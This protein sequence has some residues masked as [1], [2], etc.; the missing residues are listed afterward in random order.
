MSTISIT[1]ETPRRGG[2]RVTSATFLAKEL[3]L[4]LAWGSAPGRAS[5]TYVPAAGA[6]AVPS[7]AVVKI[8]TQGQKFTGLCMRDQLAA[9]ANEGTVRRIDWVDFRE[10]LKWDFIYAAFNIQEDRLGSNGFERVWWHVL[11][12][13]FHTGRRTYTPRPLSAD[14]ILDAC[15]GFT[16]RRHRGIYTVETEFYPTY[17]RDMDAPVIGLD[18]RQGRRLG[19]C[20]QEVSDK[21]GLVFSLDHY[22]GPYHLTWVRKGEGT[23]PTYGETGVYPANSDGREVDDNFSGHPT[24]VRVLGDRNVYQILNVPVVRDWLPAWQSFP[25]TF[26]FVRDVYLRGR[27]ANGVRFVVAAEN[28]PDNLIGWHKAGALARTISVADYASLRRRVRLAGEPDAEPYEW[29]DLRSYQGRSR[30][31]MPAWLYITSIVWRAFRPMPFKFR[32]A[33][34]FDVS[35]EDMEVESG[36]LAAVDHDPV[37]GRMRW[38]RDLPVAGQGYAVV[39]GYNVGADTFRMADPD[40][41]QL[42]QWVNYQALWTN[43]GFQVDRQPGGLPTLLFDE[44]LIKSSNFFTEVDGKAVLKA[45]PTLTVPAVRA[46][47]V[48]RAEVFSYT[49]GSGGRDDREYV[50]GLYGQFIASANQS[51]LEEIRFRDGKGVV[52]KAKEIASARLAS[53]WQYAGGGYTVKGS[54]QTRLSAMYDRVTLRTGPGGTTETVDFTKERSRD[55]FVP[56]RDLDRDLRQQSLLPGEDKLRQE[57][58]DLRLIASGLRS[59]KEV[60]RSL[61]DIFHGATDVIR[62]SG[63]EDGDELSVGTPL[64]KRPTVSGSG[65]TP[66]QDTLAAYA[67]DESHK[68]FAGVT[69]RDGEDATGQVR[70]VGGGVVPCRVQGPVEANDSVGKGDGDYL[71]PGGSPSAG[72]ALQAIAGN[73]VKLISVRL[74]GSGGAVGAADDRWA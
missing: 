20:L 73:E 38:R 39:Q 2:I 33:V 21:L 62:V 23:L 24:R 34:N 50:S 12:E 30:A 54:N 49:Q 52:S 74:A 59:G 64:W 67:P 41:F 31:G 56:E 68:V 58:R 26:D 15:L 22:R 36:L 29:V 70:V 27:D 6:V 13:H 28:D 43:V 57:A 25:D 65:E 5:I 8:E 7:G 44:P 69:V 71:V 11:P 61:Y 45:K 55:T 63:A 1:V 17:H 42:T 40:R 14:A 72:V 18:W 16:R 60:L 10:Y 47:L 9:S 3:D 32:N 19:E 66:A 46:C 4:T 35:L 53:P 48:F 51:A 37:T